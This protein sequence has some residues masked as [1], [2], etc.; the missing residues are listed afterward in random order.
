MR[1][2]RFRAGV[3]SVVGTRTRAPPR[4]LFVGD[5]A[6]A[7]EC[8]ETTPTESAHPL[9]QVAAPLC[10][11][12]CGVSSQVHRGV[13]AL[14]L[15]IAAGSGARRRWTK[16]PLQ[17]SAGLDARPDSLTHGAVLRCADSRG[18]GSRRTRSAAIRARIAARSRAGRSSS[19]T[20]RSATTGRDVVREC[21]FNRLKQ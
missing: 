19:A 6:P 12:Q 18:D 1:P 8:E 9:P 20:G 17:L 14:P 13:S 3:G 2:S 5:E 4:P 10:S 21:G 16:R 15:W 7:S 11:R